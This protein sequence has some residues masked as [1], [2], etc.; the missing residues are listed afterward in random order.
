MDTKSG[1]SQSL[2]FHRYQYD[3]HNRRTRATREDNAQW[4]YTYDTR[5]QVKTGRRHPT[6]AAPETEALAG[7]QG[8]YSYDEIGNRTASTQGGNAAGRINGRAVL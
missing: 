5:S 2:S 3:A 6:A 4:R 8:T 1:A 7:W